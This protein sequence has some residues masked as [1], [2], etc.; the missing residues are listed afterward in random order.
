MIRQ[1]GNIQKKVIYDCIKKIYKPVMYNLFLPTS[2]AEPC[3]TK[4]L[5]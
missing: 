3:R 2:T 4:I 1:D 5:E